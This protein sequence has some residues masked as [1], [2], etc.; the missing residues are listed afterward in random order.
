M[1]TT[2]I[3]SIYPLIIVSFALIL[4]MLYFAI[5]CIFFIDPLP[6][7]LFISAVSCIYT[8]INKSR[9]ITSFVMFYGWWWHWVLY[10]IYPISFINWML[11]NFKVYFYDRQLLHICISCPQKP[12]PWKNMYF[13]KK[14]NQFSFNSDS[15][16]NG[17]DLN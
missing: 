8:F 13:H 4:E 5:I 2:A 12:P 16:T 14:T 3:P 7:I 9:K 17:H 6:M 15:Q 11:I 10:K 1:P